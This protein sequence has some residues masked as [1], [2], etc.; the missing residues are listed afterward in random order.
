MGIGTFVNQKT[1]PAVKITRRAHTSTGDLILIADVIA[2][3]IFG[4]LMLYSAGTDF[5]LHTYGSATYIFNKQ[6]LWMAHWH[7]GGVSSSPGSIIT[8]GENSLYR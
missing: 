5:S 1:R 2:L 8:S 4:L 3:G 7:P 6:L